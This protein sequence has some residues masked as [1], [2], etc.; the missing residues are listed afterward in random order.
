MGECRYKL[1]LPKYYFSHQEPSYGK[2]DEVGGILAAFLGS[3]RVPGAL[4]ES[5]RFPWHGQDRLMRRD[6]YG[7]E[8]MPLQHDFYPIELCKE[9][10]GFLRSV[11]GCF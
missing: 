3:D 5:F 7:F 2:C 6:W 10:C 4:D 9:K 1:R 11:L 8:L